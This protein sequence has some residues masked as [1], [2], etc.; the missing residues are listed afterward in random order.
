MSKISNYIRS[1]QNKFKISIGGGDTVK[2]NKL[3]FSITSIG[4]AST[5][6]YRNKAKKNDDIY[7]TGN[8]GDSITGLSILKNIIRTNSRLEKYFIDKYFSP[9]LQIK[10]IKKLNKSLAL[11]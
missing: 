11:Q 5:I 8:L 7:V 6:I 4:Y 10:F 9:E 1:S 3:S 2:S